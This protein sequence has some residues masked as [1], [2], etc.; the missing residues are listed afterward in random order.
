[1]TTSRRSSRPA[2]ARLVIVTTKPL[3]RQRRIP[4]MRVY[5]VKNGKHH[6]TRSGWLCP[7][8]VQEGIGQEH[9]LPDP[10]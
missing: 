7:P 8:P 4:K 2:T 10:G 5:G 9:H 3:G 6:R 1:M